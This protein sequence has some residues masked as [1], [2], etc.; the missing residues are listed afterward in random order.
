MNKPTALVILDGFGISPEKQHNAIAQAHMPYFKHW[1]SSYPHAILKASGSAVGLPDGFQGNS[2]VGH[3]TIG[4]GQIIE[5]P[6]TTWLNKI[7]NSSFAHNQTL[8]DCLQKVQRTEKTV[9][10]MGLLSDAGVHAHEKQLYACIDAAWQAGIKKIVVHAFLDGRDTPPQSAYDYLKKLEHK[11]AYY[12]HHAC[13]GSIHGRFYAMDRDHNW[14]RTENSYRILTESQK[15]STISW[16]TALE[17]QYAHGITDEF[18]IPT[19]LRSDGIIKNGDGIIFC[20]IRPERARQLTASFVQPHF[21]DFIVKPLTL[22]FFITPI[23]YSP[24]L[25]T[26]HLFKRNLINNTLKD[27]LARQGKTIFSIAET[28]KYAHV[29]Y[30]FRGENEAPVSTETR[31]MIPSLHVA[32]YK[33]NPEMSAQKITDAVLHSLQTN[34]QDF[35]LIN[36]ANADMV[37]H[38]GDFNA[39]IRAVEF[40]DT[41]LEQLYETIVQKMNG[42]LYITADH[43]KA[44][45]MYDV[46]IHQP[47]TAHTCNPVPF[48]YINK[49]HKNSSLQLNL[50]ELSDIA[51]FIVKNME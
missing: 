34:P 39:T 40:L 19:Q 9:H 11:L 8:L 36:Y 38:S 17:K 16:E 30:F 3:I 46:S 22:T 43:G 28:E 7:E 41:Q 48:I 33:N 2:E 37:G 23:E 44:D 51:P 42:T 29:T 21:T 45:D 50:R 20:N 47:R 27:I 1:L 24:E 25:P 49:E 10:I 4:A 35:Y 32:T 13:I 6:M 26:I 31:V 15:T 14:Q 18:I 12:N 5:Q